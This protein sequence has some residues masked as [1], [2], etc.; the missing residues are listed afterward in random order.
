MQLAVEHNLKWS[1]KRLVILV[2]TCSLGFDGAK[3]CI[4][5]AVR[6]AA[7]P[8]GPAVRYCLDSALPSGF[9][10]PIV[11]LVIFTQQALRR[12]KHHLEKQQKETV[13]EEA[14]Q[15]KAQQ[16]KDPSD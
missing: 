10:G 8:V 13:K 15:G 9:F 14:Q 1:I 12:A 16:G 7:G 11:A 5:H 4:L 3:Q 6:K 2:P